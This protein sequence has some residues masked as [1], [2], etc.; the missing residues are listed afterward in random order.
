M[1]RIN[2]VGELLKQSPRKISMI[3]I[4]ALLEIFSPWCKKTQETDIQNTNTIEIIDTI[5]TKQ[6]VTYQEIP[7]DVSFDSARAIG[8]I[9]LAIKFLQIGIPENTDSLSIDE[10]YT[11]AMRY[12]NLA[13]C[14]YRQWSYNSAIDNIK[15]WL[16][17]FESPEAEN[18]MYDEIRYTKLS[19]LYKLISSI[20]IQKSED[21]DTISFQIALDYAYK[22]YYFAQRAG[23]TEN[24]AGQMA[25]LNTCYMQLHQGDSAKKYFD[26]AEQYL[27]KEN[28][29]LLLSNLYGNY[30]IG[31][32]LPEKD[33]KGAIMMF[34]KAI[35]TLNQHEE[36][37]DFYNDM[38]TSHLTYLAQI[39]LDIWDMNNTKDCYHR[40]V[41]LPPV[42][43]EDL[44]F[45][46]EEILLLIEEK[47]EIENTRY[48]KRKKHL[49]TWDSLRKQAN[50]KNM[51]DLH[52][53]EQKNEIVKQDAALKT[54]QAE[55]KIQEAEI[56]RKK[57]MNILLWTLGILALLGA[58]AIGL[59]LKSKRKQN[60]VLAGKNAEIEA[61]KKL[62]EEQKEI[63][64]KKNKDIT[65]GIKAA[66]VH[67][68]QHLLMAR[69]VL[70]QH[71]VENFIFHQPHSIV[72]GDFYRA[73][74][75]NGKIYVLTAD[76]TG[77]GVRG[78]F[79]S[80]AIKDMLNEIVNK[81]N[82]EDPAMMFDISRDKIKLQ[83]KQQ[84]GGDEIQDGMDATLC[85]YDF[86]NK[87][88][89]YAG[90]KA[91]V[92]ILRANNNIPEGYELLECKWDNQP[93][94]AYMTEKPF[95]TYNKELQSGDII[96]TSS[97][98]YQD[99]FGGPDK[100]KFMKGAF[101]ELLYSLRG[102]SIKEQQ[103]ILDETFKE[104]KGTVDQTDDVLVIGIR[105]P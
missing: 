94:G 9:D 85:V 30:A 38:K 74:E 44:N 92:R 59:A 97:D 102:K 78:A 55:I 96:I 7:A 81:D 11:V 18:I 50:Q 69:N 57:T 68:N 105:V 36:R 76:C 22:D 24:Y 49:D 100:K 56:E 83:N 21:F 99:Q 3:A 95:S 61:Q 104:R 90:A 10:K 4:L 66:A 84:E 72:G 5:K 91:S 42:T 65:D 73:T 41:E 8:D 43:D 63:V 2:A 29:M 89:Q 28:N 45:K 32:Y 80:Q 75:K 23:N 103:K 35:I 14:Y 54:K 79:M 47:Y 88:L 20:Y 93:V 13:V 58:W 71:Q 39:Y 37:D 51:V 101:K 70:K 64:E 1:N 27:Q 98:G 19:L 16:S 48:I 31:N 86:V 62:V 25:N 33:Y 34:K 67:Q 15:Q 77:H 60:K 26:L 53:G 82:V 40:L 52:V 17:F 6:K 87:S 46:K 12:Y